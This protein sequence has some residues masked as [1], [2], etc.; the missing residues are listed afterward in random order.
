MRTRPSTGRRIPQN[1]LIVENAHDNG[2]RASGISEDA[3]CIGR[4]ATARQ[5]S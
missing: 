4:R 2:P 3:A 1:P 5:E